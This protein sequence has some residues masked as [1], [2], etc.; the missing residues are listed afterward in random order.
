[1]T[2]HLRRAG[3]DDAALIHHL[4]NEMAAAEGGRIKGTPELIARHGF[5]P[6]PRF[7]VVL[8][9]AEA[10][11]GLVLYF[12]EYSSWRGQMGV[13]VQDLYLGPAARGLG[14]GRALL[15]AA[16]RDAASDADWVPEF[17]TLMVAHK[18]TAALGFYG[19]LGFA[20]RDNADPLILAGEGL[21]ALIA[22]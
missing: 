5:G 15:A 18:N 14:L 6:N 12:P 20:P 7:R 9:L 13:F 19:A 3:A 10:P 8:A 16:F 21:A 22:R 11:L 2:P 1:M 4:L 17:L